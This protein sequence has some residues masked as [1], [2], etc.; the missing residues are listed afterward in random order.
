MAYVVE[1]ALD[2]LMV[3]VAT[4]DPERVVRAR[5]VERMSTPRLIIHAC[6]MAIDHPCVQDG[7]HLGD[8][9]GRVASLGDGGSAVSLGASS[10]APDYF[11]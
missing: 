1:M 6:K 4:A 2:G 9:P 3:V 7:D 10:A 8:G 5:G 11:P